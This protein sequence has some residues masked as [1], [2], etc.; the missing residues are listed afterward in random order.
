MSGDDAASGS[1]FSSSNVNVNRCEN[2]SMVAHF[3]CILYTAYVAY[4]SQPGTSELISVSKM[5]VLSATE[6]TVYLDH[7]LW[8]LEL[9]S[10]RDLD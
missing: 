9:P 2:I 5:L 3:V 6:T 4:T 7:E 1:N 8:K 10:I